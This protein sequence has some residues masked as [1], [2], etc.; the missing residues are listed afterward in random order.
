MSS[1]LSQFSDQNDS[2]VIQEISH[3]LIIDKCKVST[4]VQFDSLKGKIDGL[5]VNDAL[6]IFLL[7]LGEIFDS[8][9]L[10]IIQYYYERIKY[11]QW[12]YVY[13]SR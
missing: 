8:K 4:R 13:E 10:Y 9:F 1:E 3:C 5:E 11:N 6:S 7:I 2:M 12:E